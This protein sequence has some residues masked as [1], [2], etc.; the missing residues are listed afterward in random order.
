MQELTQSGNSTMQTIIMGHPLH[1]KILIYWHFIKRIV[2]K[3]NTDRFSLVKTCEKVYMSLQRTSTF[4]FSSYWWQNEE[5]FRNM[6]N[7]TE[8]IGSWTV[9]NNYN[10]TLYSQVTNEYRIYF[11]VF[12]KN[13][14]TWIIF[15]IDFLIKF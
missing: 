11:S 7:V 6:I 2:Q 9:S 15:Q 5:F 1:S 4:P 8:G 12:F 14:H 3:Y 13:C 10:K